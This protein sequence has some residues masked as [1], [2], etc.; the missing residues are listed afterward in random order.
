MTYLIKIYHQWWQRAYAEE[1]S[2]YSLIQLLFG[3]PSR[4]V[5]SWF[6]VMGIKG[7]HTVSLCW[8]SLQHWGHQK[9]HLNDYFSLVEV[10]YKES[11][12]SVLF[13]S[14]F[15][16]YLGT[17][18]YLWM[19]LVVSLRDGVCSRWAHFSSLW[20]VGQKWNGSSE[21]ESQAQRFVVNFH[22]GPYNN[23]SVSPFWD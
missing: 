5:E 6:I 19:Q 7:G 3:A 15:C 1:W 4:K 2:V 8:H 23:L 13:C 16:S 11:I 21:N 20:I 12:Y 18:G 17:S 14:D 10:S 22:E 9:D